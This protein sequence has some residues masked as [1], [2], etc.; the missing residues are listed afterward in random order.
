MAR[1]SRDFSVGGFFLHLLQIR[2]LLGQISCSRGL[3]PGWLRAKVW[4]FPSW[5]SISEPNIHEDAGSIPGL[6]QWV[7]DPTLP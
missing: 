4:E 2:S 1:S 6:A 5:L 3:Y 7:K